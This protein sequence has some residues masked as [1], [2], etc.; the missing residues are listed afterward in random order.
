[1]REEMV[2]TIAQIIGEATVPP[3]SEADTI[4]RVIHPLLMAADY[5]RLDI[6]AEATDDNRQKPDFT[7]LPDTDHTWFLEAKAWNV[8][9]DEKQAHQAINY[10]NT[11]GRRWAVLTNGQVW[12]LY[13]NNIRD[14]IDAKL[15]CSSTLTSDSFPSFLE[16]ISKPS[17]V[18]GRVA[19]YVT[20]QRLFGHLEAQLADRSSDSIKALLKVVRQRPGLSDVTAEDVA[21]FFRRQTS[22][23]GVATTRVERLS[24][25]PEAVSKPTPIGRDGHPLQSAPV[26]GKRPVALT[27]ADGTE[28]TGSNWKQITVSLARHLLDSNRLKNLPYRPTDRWKA[29]L[30]ARQEDAAG[31]REPVRFESGGCSFVVETHFSAEAHV[32]NWI[33]LL[34]EGGVRVEACS[35]RLQEDAGK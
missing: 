15:A 8:R 34:K 22:D 6:R 16:A 24:R 18:S 11:Q 30:V 29:P 2:A 10:A 3:A 7:I 19:L 33:S 32:N 17:M 27:L 28:L 20:N 25:T 9:L 1:M 12:R 21:S 4:H 23:T 13:D 26:T 35:L 14:T 5:G 31:I